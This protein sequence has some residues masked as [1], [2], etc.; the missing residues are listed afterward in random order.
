M[1]NQETRVRRKRRR[2]HPVLN[3]LLCA[4]IGTACGL[5]GGWFAVTHMGNAATV[6]YQSDSTG[7]SQPSNVKNTE[8]S[9]ITISEAAEKAAPS[10]VEIVVEGTS[11]SY[12]MFGGTYTTK[13]AGSGV[14]ISETGY[15]ITNNHVVEDS[16]KITVKTYDGKEYDATLVGTDSKTDIAVIKITASGLTPAVIGDSSK[17]AQGDTAIVIGNPLGTLG[18]TVTSGIISAVS[19]EIVIDRE[20]MNLIQTDATINSGNSG[21][22]MFDGNGN[23]IGIVNAKDSGTTSTGTVIE[24][25]G[26]AI[27]V[28][29]AMEIASQLMESGKVTNRATLGVYLQELTRNTQQ[30][31]A[32]LYI[33]DIISG[34]GAEAAGL[35]AY[36]R[37]IKVDGT[38]VEGY[39]DLSKLLR[40]KNV[41]DTIEVV[42][43]RNGEEVTAQVTLTGTLETPSTQG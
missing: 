10:V 29:T 35:Q 8:T 11:T 36:D 31:K 33:T 7:T 34:S 6:V 2:Y 17:I 41:G 3:M 9:A 18:G 30:Y 12:G 20:S 25:I 42:V 19:R 37:I 5:G 43:E 32:G 26:F 22:G 13:G 1:T 15:I 4:V 21:G 40:D 24:G 14:I 39:T 23:L 38:E 16:N 28:N 27:P